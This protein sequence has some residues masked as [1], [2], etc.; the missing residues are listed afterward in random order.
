MKLYSRYKNF[1]M[2][3]NHCK[4]IWKYVNDNGVPNFTYNDVCDLW[5]EFSQLWAAGFLIPDHETLSQ[6]LDWL[7][8]KEG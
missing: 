2:H 1:G 8:M 5:I 7:E 4:E 6:F 3:E